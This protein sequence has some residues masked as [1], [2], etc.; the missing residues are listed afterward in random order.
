VLFD[1]LLAE[2][3]L[4]PRQIRGYSIEE[5]THLAV[6][7]TVASG[8]ADAT[9]GIEAA[10]ARHGLDFVPVATEQYLLAIRIGRLKSPPVAGLRKLMGSASFRAACSE[11]AGYDLSQA[12][13][14][15]RLSSIVRAQDA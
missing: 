4:N 10:A 12:G 11:L 2:A 7:A 6:A 3:G 14:I 1:R 9:F 5:Y 8:M 15:T 13:R